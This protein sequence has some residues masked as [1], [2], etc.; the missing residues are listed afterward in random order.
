MSAPARFVLPSPSPPRR[1][2][3]RRL[4]R[5]GNV[6]LCSQV[7]LQILL[8]LRSILRL[9]K[10]FRD[11][12]MGRHSQR[13]LWLQI[14]PEMSGNRRGCRWHRYCRCRPITKRAEEEGLSKSCPE[15]LAKPLPKIAARK[16]GEVPDLA[17]PLESYFLERD[18]KECEE[19]LRSKGAQSPSK[20]DP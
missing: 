8:R 4:N 16:K 7:I 19:W 5:T 10:R 17:D 2:R 12:F 6:A 1:R 15:V 3:R 14:L 13:L 20:S 11:Y 9:L 18:K